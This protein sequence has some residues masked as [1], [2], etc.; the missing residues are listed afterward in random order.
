MLSVSALASLENQALSFLSTIFS[1]RVSS[2]NLLQSQNGPPSYF[3][4]QE[5]GR[6][7]GKN[8][9]ESQVSLLVRKSLQN[10]HPI[11]SDYIGQNLV[12]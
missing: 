12:T 4:Q 9:S 7:Q 3:R 6:N 10:T 2:S 5:S 8:I 1:V 11:I